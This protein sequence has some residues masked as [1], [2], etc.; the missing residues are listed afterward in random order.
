MAETVR[1]ES[2][3]RLERVRKFAIE[4]MEQTGTFPTARPIQIKFFEHQ[5][6]GNLN[7][8]ASD[9]KVVAKDISLVYQSKQTVDIDGDQIEIPREALEYTVRAYQLIELQQRKKF[10]E[11]KTEAQQE[12]ERAKE[13]RDAVQAKFIA[14]GSELEAKAE[15]LRLREEQLQE[16]KEKMISQEKELQAA[17]TTAREKELK[18]NVLMTELTVTREHLSAQQEQH[19]KEITRL[20]NKVLALQDKHD[21]QLSEIQ[22]SHNKLMAEHEALKSTHHEMDG[23]LTHVTEERDCFNEEKER[24]KTQSI[25]LRH[26][27]SGLK[28]S[29]QALSEERNIQQ[30]QIGSLHDAIELLNGKIVSFEGHLKGLS[31]Q[32]IQEPTEGKAK[33]V[34]SKKTNTRTRK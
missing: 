4:H 15:V 7:S 27:L 29:N 23:K 33:V 31:G 10:D 12:T 34:A 17:Q 16:I 22:A 28:A 8:I 32:T 30:N 5:Y 20:D 14:M 9:L 11:F 13:E 18:N 21:T 1:A 26:E 3:E 6:P 19:D 2:L 25:N 24:F